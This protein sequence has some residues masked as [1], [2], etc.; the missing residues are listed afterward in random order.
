MRSLLEFYFLSLGRYFGH[1]LDG[2][3]PRTL[4]TL[5]TWALRGARPSRRTSVTMSAGHESTRRRSI[6]RHVSL[7]ADAGVFSAVVSRHPP[8][9]LPPLSGSTHATSTYSARGVLLLSMTAMVSQRRQRIAHPDHSWI[10]TQR[11]ENKI[12][13][14]SQCQRGHCLGKTFTGHGHCRREQVLAGPR[15]LQLP[16]KHRNLVGDDHRGR[17]GSCSRRTLLHQ[18]AS[19][20]ERSVRSSYRRYQHNWSVVHR[21]RGTSPHRQ[22][23]ALNLSPIVASSS[24]AVLWSI[25]AHFDSLHG[26]TLAKSSGISAAERSWGSMWRHP[27][28]RVSSQAALEV[29][30]NLDLAPRKSCGH[31]SLPSGMCSH[32]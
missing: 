25:H 12:R 14:W 17:H 15:R 32:D 6:C 1:D 26:L 7:L 4:F 23:P 29:P 18:T 8:P 28:W 27:P 31:E 21:L 10:Q 11:C 5:P 3:G 30:T 16:K 2:L 19:P 24:H 20:A 13:M 22:R 9:P